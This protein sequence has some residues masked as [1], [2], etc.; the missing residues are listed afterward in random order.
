MARRIG[1]MPGA[2]RFGFDDTRGA[3]GHAKISIALEAPVENVVVV[4]DHRRS[5]QDQHARAAARELMILKVPPSR[6]AG[7]AF[8]QAGDLSVNDRKA[9]LFPGQAVEIDG[10]GGAINPGAQWL[11]NLTGGVEL[12]GID[13]HAVGPANRRIHI[14]HIEL[15]HGALVKDG[16]EATAVLDPGKV[17]DGAQ[18][19]VEPETETPVLPANLRALDLKAGAKRLGNAD[20]SRPPAGRSFQLLVVHGSFR[21]RRDA[22]VDHLENFL[23]GRVDFDLQAFNAARPAEVDAVRVVAAAHHDAVAFKFG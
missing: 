22:F 23:F 21:D 17:D 20:G 12:A 8:K 1:R 4:A 18:T 9:V 10:I 5:A 13:E 7:V 2:D 16:A 15:R 14:R 19:R 6:L 3:D 11:Q